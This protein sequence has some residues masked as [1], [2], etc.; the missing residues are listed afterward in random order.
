MFFIHSRELQLCATLMKNTLISSFYFPSA[1]GHHPER[2]EDCLLTALV[3]EKVQQAVSDKVE[4]LS[5]P[6]SSRGG[7][8]R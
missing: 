6:G 3:A 2:D 4:A 1:G 7:T 8:L 5:T